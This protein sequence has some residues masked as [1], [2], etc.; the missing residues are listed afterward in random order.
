MLT[1]MENTMMHGSG[2]RAVRSLFGPL[3]AILSLAGLVGCTGHAGVVGTSTPP[4]WE[5][6]VT[7]DRELRA[8]GLRELRFT[9]ARTDSGFLRVVGEYFNQSD[10]KLST[11]YRFTWIDAAGQPIDTLLGNWQAVNALPR[12]RATFAG[13][14]PRGDVESFRVEL[15]SASRLRGRS[16]PPPATDR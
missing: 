3:L 11:V 14:A 7:V 13:I 6:Y 9:R 2:C 10:S 16:P 4:W 15:V 12:T 8:R 1:L 5:P